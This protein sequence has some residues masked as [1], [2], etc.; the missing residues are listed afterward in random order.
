M[1]FWEQIL[2]KYPM[3]LKATKEDA[4]NL[5]IVFP[6]WFVANNQG[7]RVIFAQLLDDCMWNV[8]PSKTWTD[9]QTNK[10]IALET[11]TD[12]VLYFYQVTDFDLYT[13]TA[14][15]NNKNVI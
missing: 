6:E 7:E 2:L 10:E 4:E 3:K 15:F 13:G 8:P 11:L 14:K 1:I 5:P 12:V 9:Y